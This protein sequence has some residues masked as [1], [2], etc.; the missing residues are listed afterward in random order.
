MRSNLNSSRK[1]FTLIELLI[2]IGIF[3]G[4]TVAFTSIFVSILR[5]YNRQ[6]ATAE[7]A[8]QSQ[9]LLQTVQNQVQRSVAIDMP[10]DFVTS[11]L[12][13]RMPDIT[14]PTIIYLS[15]NMV[16]MRVGTSTSAQPLTNSRVKITNLSFTRHANPPGHDVV[17]VAFSL[18]NVTNNIQ[19]YF[20]QDLTTAIARVS[21][22]T[23]DSDV[24]ASSSNTYNL[25]T[26]V[27]NWRS[28]NSTIYFNGANVGVGAM[29]PTA[30]FQVSGGDFYAD[31]VGNGIILKAPNATCWRVT[32]SNVGAFVSASV[33]CP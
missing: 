32:V 10:T 19:N 26:A 16:Y 11:T 20:S 24:V 8:R 3:A 9:F 5:V 28:I 12:T 18:E 15:N 2:F 7:V 33:T 17:D 13:L 21:A 14:D 1:A 31:T 6:S 25:G 4:V 30:K 23:F 27:G 22:S 29:T